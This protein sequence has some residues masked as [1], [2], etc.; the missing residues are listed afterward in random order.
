MSAWTELPVP[1]SERV[2]FASREWVAEADRYLQAN[3]AKAGSALD[4]LET[5]LTER[6][7]NAP[8]HL[9]FKDNAAGFSLRIR[10]G[11]VEVGVGPAGEAD[12]E[13]DGDYN[14]VLPIACTIY[15]GDAAIQQRAQREYSK[16]MREPIKRQGQ[17]PEH[18]G[19]M[20][21]LGGLHDHMARR[22]IN[23]P[24]IDH[25][26]ERYGLRGNVAELEDQGYT[27]L[28]NAFT[29]ELADELRDEADRI[30]D[31]QPAEDGWKAA[32]LL[33]RG[34]LWE[35]A[36]V[37]PWVLTLADYLLGRGGTAAIVE[38]IRKYAGDDTHPG[39][40]TDYS[41]WRVQAPYPEQCLEATAVWALDD[42]TADAGPTVFLPHSWKR[43]E[44]VAPGATREDCVLLEM[45]KGSI[46]FW[47]GASW[48][49]S[50]LRTA[51][52]ARHS[53]HIAYCNYMLRSF[54]RYDTI[55]PAIAER[56]P[57]VFQTL[58]G[59]DDP[60]G[61]T[62]ASKGADRARATYAATAGYGSSKPLHR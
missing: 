21:V 35:E 61:K 32:Q 34:R 3:V 51:P 43:R 54:D 25:R 33:H 31:S 49:G 24:D 13:I 53:L 12:T 46:A 4:G 29:D 47:H 30:H 10:D 19:I 17:M 28:E 38:T 27:I 57:P 7:S 62:E 45:P 59:L 36:V 14:S 1:L 48:H 41:G 44:P 23:N 5:S 40:H 26:I 18:P 9:G 39:L 58:C 60:F 20:Q 11:K 56:N 6:W 15:G 55:D 37:H 16:L 52:G 8:P 22:T 2:E 42:F 50:Q